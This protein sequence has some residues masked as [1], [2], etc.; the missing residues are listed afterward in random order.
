MLPI[1]KSPSRMRGTA[2]PPATSWTSP[3]VPVAERD[4]PPRIEQPQGGGMDPFLRSLPG[5]ERILKVDGSE[6]KAAMGVAGLDDILAGGLRR[7]RVYLVEGNPGTGKTTIATQFLFEGGAR[8]ERGRYI[9]L[10]ETEAEVGEGP[11]SPGLDFAE[12]NEI[13]ERVPPES[14]LGDEQ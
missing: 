1:S 10:A 9:T 3:T 13:L 6:L 12:P 14:L 2:T 4:P 11:L 8:R 5:A 7:G